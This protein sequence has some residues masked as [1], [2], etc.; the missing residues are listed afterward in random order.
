MEI[1]KDGP[2]ARAG[3]LAVENNIAKVM[4]CFP[5]AVVMGVVAPTT[6]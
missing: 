3:I 5:G 2:S 1:G 6:P 4:A